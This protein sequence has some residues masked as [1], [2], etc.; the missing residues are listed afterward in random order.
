MTSSEHLT[1]SD[2]VAEAAEILRKEGKIFD[3]VANVQGDM[4]F[5]DPEV[6]NLTVDC[7]AQ[8]GDEIGMS[9]VATPILTEGE[10]LRPSSVK[11]VLGVDNLVLYF[12]RSPVPYVREPGELNVNEQ[13]PY[14]YRH[15]GLYVFRPATL[16]K[17]SSLP[18]S[19]P[20]Q[21]EKLEQ[22]RA[23]CNGIRIKVAIVPEALVRSQ[24]EVDT[25]ED[26]DKA[27]KIA[28]SFRG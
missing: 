12:S 27:R 24:V 1:G 13:T 10:F 23:L 18:Q 11:A 19:L 22:L 16:A 14:G 8:S 25:N 3:L 21:R 7:L 26:L 17:L 9:T 2:R 15:M 5:I 20:E 28:A 6:I 4:P